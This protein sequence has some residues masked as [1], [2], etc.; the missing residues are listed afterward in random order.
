VLTPRRIQ[1][2]SDSELLERLTACA[3][4][5]VVECATCATDYRVAGLAID[6][7]ATPP[8]HFLCPV[9]RNNLADPVRGHTETYHRFR[10]GS[11]ESRS[12]P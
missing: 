2:L 10:A 1:D 5:C 6:V 7:F 4:D 9:C 3:D 12:F 8:R 11:G